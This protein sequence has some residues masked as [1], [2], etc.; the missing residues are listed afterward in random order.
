[1]EVLEFACTKEGKKIVIE[2]E[3]LLDINEPLSINV[4]N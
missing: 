1:L 3:I 4:L 2:D